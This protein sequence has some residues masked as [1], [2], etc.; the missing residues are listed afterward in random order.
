MADNGGNKN[1]FKFAF[2]SQIHFMPLYM[3]PE[4]RKGENDIPGGTKANFI[5]VTVLAG[6]VADLGKKENRKMLKKFR[7]TRMIMI[8]NLRVCIILKC[9]KLA[10]VIS[11]N[12]LVMANCGAFVNTA[13]N[14]HGQ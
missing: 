3:S 6:Y 14:V 2:T 7:G 9:L 1:R 8:P 12:K 13:T 4:G 5:V 11:A 10:K